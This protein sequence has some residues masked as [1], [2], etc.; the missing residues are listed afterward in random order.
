M[1]IVKEII[2]TESNRNTQNNFLQQQL[3]QFCDS[4]NIIYLI[5]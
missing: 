2:N 3:T 1:V 4:Q 5:L